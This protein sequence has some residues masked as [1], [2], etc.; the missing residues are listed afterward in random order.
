MSLSQNTWNNLFEGRQ[1]EVVSRRFICNII[2]MILLSTQLSH[3]EFCPI[4]ILFSRGEVGHLPS[5]FSDKPVYFSW[6]V[7]RV[8][9]LR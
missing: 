4:N 5:L 6:H 2:A 9:Q 8:N 7:L 1:V 3:L